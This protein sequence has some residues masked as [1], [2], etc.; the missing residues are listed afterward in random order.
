MDI[1]HLPCPTNTRSIR[2]IMHAS[3]RISL[4]SRSA[5]FNMDQDEEEDRMAV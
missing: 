2:R 4:A 1:A 3:P 5:L